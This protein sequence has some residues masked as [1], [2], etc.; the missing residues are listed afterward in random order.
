MEARDDATGE[1]MTVKSSVEAGS[2]ASVNLLLPGTGTVAGRWR[3]RTASRSKGST[4][5]PPSARTSA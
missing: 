1:Q 2:A 4:S 3:A 5:S